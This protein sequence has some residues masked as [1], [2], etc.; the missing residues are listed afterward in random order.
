AE[1]GKVVGL[2][3]DRDICM[4]ANLKNQRLSNLAVEDV[5]SGDVYACKPEEDIRS[6]LKIM[7]ENKVRR[8]PVIAT[9][10]TLQGLLSMNDLVLKADEPKE[11]KAPELS[12]GDVVNTYKSICQHRSPLQ[13]QATAGS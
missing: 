9:D 2:I 8:L 3:T 11:K 12:Y 1:G 7:Q 13:A 4:A 5:I 6:A 10:G